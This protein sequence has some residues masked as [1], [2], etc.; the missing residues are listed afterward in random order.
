VVRDQLL[1]EG[2]F[3]VAIGCEIKTD[4]RPFENLGIAINQSAELP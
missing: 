1:R 3:D 2:R 4:R